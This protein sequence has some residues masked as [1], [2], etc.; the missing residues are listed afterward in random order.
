MQLINGV[1]TPEFSKTNPPPVMAVHATR[2][3]NS[4]IAVKLYWVGGKKNPLAKVELLGT[5]QT[6]T[7]RLNGEIAARELGNH[8]YQLAVLSG[9][10]LWVI[11]PKQFFRPTR[12]LSFKVASHRLLRPIATDTLFDRLSEATGGVWDETDVTKPKD[13]AEDESP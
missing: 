6:A 1:A 10:G 8:L 3:V 2:K 13:D 12:L 11:D 5:K 7:V 9:S 4:E